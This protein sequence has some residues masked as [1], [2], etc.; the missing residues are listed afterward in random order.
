[1]K[2]SLNPRSRFGVAV[3]TAFLLLFTAKF[4]LANDGGEQSNKFWGTEYTNCTTEVMYSNPQTGQ[5]MCA[6][7]CT[8]KYYVFWIAVDSDERVLTNIVAC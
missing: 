7:Y 4:V 8:Q 6:V 3:L 5:Q 1:M 2:L